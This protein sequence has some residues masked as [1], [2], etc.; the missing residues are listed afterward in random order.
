MV[1]INAEHLSSDPDRLSTTSANDLDWRLNNGM[2]ENMLSRSNRLGNLALKRAFPSH[3]H[4]GILSRAEMP[5]ISQ[6]QQEP[7][8]PDQ[9]RQLHRRIS[10]QQKDLKQKPS[11]KLCSRQNIELVPTQRLDLRAKHISGHLNSLSRNHIIRSEPV[12]SLLSKT[13][14]PNQAGDRPVCT[15]RQH[16]TSEILMSVS[17]PG[18]NAWWFNNG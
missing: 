7:I 5:Q 13:N 12:P 4:A 11:P 3:Y 2:G 9:N 14:P 17:S 10:N 16:Q 18:G 8:Y 1:G 15:P 6:S